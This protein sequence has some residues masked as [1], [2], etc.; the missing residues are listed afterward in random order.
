MIFSSLDD[1]LSHLCCCRVS[2]LINENRSTI[3]RI[4]E[5]KKNHVRL[6]IHKMFESA[7]L[8]VLQAVSDFIVRPKKKDL[9]SLL[10]RYIDE[11]LP[12]Y[13]KPKLLNLAKLDSK[14]LFYDL[15]PLYQDLNSAYF[16]DRLSLSITWFGEKT[17][18]RSRQM[19]YG[20]YQEDQK[21]IKIHRLLDQKKCPEF[22]LSYVIYHEM[23]H[24]LHPPEQ[25]AKRKCIHPPAFRAAEKKFKYYPQAIAWEKANRHHFFR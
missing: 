21:L 13:I 20:L 24:A 11:Q 25:R 4:L 9:A 8:E 15:T 12:S 17:K 14:G 2:L 23:L 6:S 18:R 3:I 1:T 22:Y 19:T 5:K 7:P 16:E 10:R